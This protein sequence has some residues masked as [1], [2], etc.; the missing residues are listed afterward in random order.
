VVGALTVVHAVGELRLWEMYLT[1][2]LLGAA[3]AVQ[4]TALSSTVPLLV[5]KEQLARANGLLGTAR[6]TAEV[7]GPALG[8]VLLATAG[9]GVVLAADLASFVIAL[10]TLQFVR[11]TADDPAAAPGGRRRL[12][13]ESLD[14]MRYLLARPSLRALVIIVF[15][16]NLVMVFGYA[17]LPSMI[18]ARTGDDSTALASV[19][20]SVGIGGIAGGLLLAAW[21]GPRSRVRGMLVGIIGMC[22]TSQVV[23]AV[24]QQVPAWCAAILAGAVLMA[25]VNGTEQAL[26]QANVPSDRLGRVFGAVLFMSQGSVLVATVAAGPLADYVFEPQAA[27]GTGLVDLLRPLVGAGPGTGMATMLLLAG[28]CG[29]AVAVWGLANG[30]VRDLERSHPTPAGRDRAAALEPEH[31]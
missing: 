7:C 19:L 8:G 22:L 2:T 20:S 24:V 17:V 5:G 9:F 6:S 14:G 26:I 28:V 21:G 10:L 13:A 25:V 11:F 31:T 27:R 23:M 30:P 1:A 29:I 18:L 4:Y 16:I 12:V 3:A 15:A